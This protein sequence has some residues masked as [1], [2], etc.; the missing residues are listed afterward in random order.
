M[1]KLNGVENEED[2]MI[3]WSSCQST[4]S[5]SDYSSKSTKEF[6]L[7]LFHLLLMLSI[8]LLTED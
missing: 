8:F 5:T 1:S 2:K 4:A 6:S 7:L 3:A